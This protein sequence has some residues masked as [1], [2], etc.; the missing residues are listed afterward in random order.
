MQ[1]RVRKC[2]KGVK[3]CPR[4]S[5]WQPF[6]RDPEFLAVILVLDLDATDPR[7]SQED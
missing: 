4:A 6:D 2:A 7:L 1:Y 5:C 3:H